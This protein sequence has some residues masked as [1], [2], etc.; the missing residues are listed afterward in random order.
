MSMNHVPQDNSTI[1][2]T[3]YAQESI[4]AY[5]TTRHG[6]IM[7]LTQHKRTIFPV[8]SRGNVPYLNSFIP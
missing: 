2:A 3:R 5:A 1:V 4:F 8:S 7:T 6:A